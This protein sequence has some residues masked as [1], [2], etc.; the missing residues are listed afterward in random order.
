MRK[1][2]QVSFVDA[3]DEMAH[4]AASVALDDV[5]GWFRDDGYTYAQLREVAEEHVDR[6]MED[7]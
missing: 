6:V 1:A 7:D 2:P 4:Y 5:L 3:E